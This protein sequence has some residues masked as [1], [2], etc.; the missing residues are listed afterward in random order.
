MHCGEATV[1]VVWMCGVLK[2]VVRR[3]A[4]GANQTGF[5]HVDV[6]FARHENMKGRTGTFIT[7]GNGP[8]T[9]SS[10]KERLVTKSFTE[11]DW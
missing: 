3:C 9:A 11:M 10:Q 1:G 8:V 2:I 4:G 7:V 5:A 6:S